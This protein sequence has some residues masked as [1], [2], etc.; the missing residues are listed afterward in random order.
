MRTVT[1]LFGDKA[2]AHII[3]QNMRVRPGG[4]GLDPDSI[5]YWDGHGKTIL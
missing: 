4:Y 2:G 3:G 5:E 1:F